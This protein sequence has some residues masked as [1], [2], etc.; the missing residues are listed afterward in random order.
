M[1]GG[2]RTR[3][4]H[5][6]AGIGAHP[7]EGGSLPGNC[8]PRV[9]PQ[10]G[11]IGVRLPRHHAHM[12]WWAWAVLVLVT[13][14]AICAAIVGVVARVASLRRAAEAERLIRHETADQEAA[15]AVPDVSS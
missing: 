12:H 8:I 14:I 9:F 13:W 1:E 2:E 4:R 6:A 15:A 10:M 7:S 3:S 11:E 5:A